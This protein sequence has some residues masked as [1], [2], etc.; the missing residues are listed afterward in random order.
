MLDTVDISALLG[1]NDEVLS[2]DN[3][4]KQTTVGAVLQQKDVKLLMLYYTM[5]NCPGCR[6][7][8]PILVELYREVNEDQKQ[9]EVIGV[10][11]DRNEELYNEYYAEMPWPAIPIKDKR[12]K[13]IAKQF[14]IKGLPQLIVVNAETWE[15]VSV[16]AVDTVASLGPVILE[17]WMNRLY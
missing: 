6:E 12:I 3:S 10:I 17:R 9:L 14:S 16:N 4:G 5:H 11:T 7:F 1:G 2:A 15:I 8:T 13:A